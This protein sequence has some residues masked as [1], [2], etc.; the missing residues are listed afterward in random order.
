MQQLKF[1]GGSMPIIGFGTF[2]LKGAEAEKSVATALELGY[3]H[4]DTAQMYGNEAEVGRALAGSGLKRDEV[5]VTTKIEPHNYAPQA[6]SDSLEKSL[7]DLRLEQVDLLLLHWPNPQYPMKQTVELLVA[8]REAG[9]ARHV[10]VSN[11]NTTD[12][13]RAAAMAGST[14]LATNQV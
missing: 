11:L 4:L 9:K 5:F 12:V 1:R 3:R 8:A 7:R 10:G 14:P 13:K 6:F 2:P